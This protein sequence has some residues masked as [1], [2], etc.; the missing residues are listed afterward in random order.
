M[1]TTQTLVALLPLVTA[2]TG[3]AMGPGSYRAAALAPSAPA[4]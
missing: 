1:N 4:P 2:L 3:C